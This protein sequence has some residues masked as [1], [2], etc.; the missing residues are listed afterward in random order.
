MEASRRKPGADSSARA[1][2]W[3]RERSACSWGEEGKEEKAHLEPSA[4]SSGR[5]ECAASCLLRK[6][7]WPSSSLVRERARVGGKKLARKKNFP[8]LDFPSN[9]TEAVESMEES[10]RTRGTSDCTPLG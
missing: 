8:E 5:P 9:C 3:E 4:G 6:V 10:T 7:P 1:R 2:W